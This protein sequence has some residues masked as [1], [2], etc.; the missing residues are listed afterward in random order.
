VLPLNSIE[1]FGWEKPQSTSN[2]RAKVFPIKP[3]YKDLI[4][5]GILNFLCWIDEEHNH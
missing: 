5:D 3:S 4:E 1:I 2:V